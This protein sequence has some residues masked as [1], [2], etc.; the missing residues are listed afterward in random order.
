MGPGGKYFA[1]HRNF[2]IFADFNGS[3]QPGQT[4]SNNNGVKF[5]FHASPHFS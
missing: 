4:G 1:D 5:M 2:G 3:T